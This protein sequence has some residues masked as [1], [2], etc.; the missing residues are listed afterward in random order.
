MDDVEDETAPETVVGTDDTGVVEIAEPGLP[1]ATGEVTPVAPVTASDEASLTPEVV[2]AFEG[3][4]PGATDE[5]AP[6]LARVWIT[7]EVVAAPATP[8]VRVGGGAAVEE[9]AEVSGSAQA[10]PLPSP[11]HATSP[12]TATL[13]SR[14]IRPIRSRPFSHLTLDN[15]STSAC[16]PLQL[17]CHGS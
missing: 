16:R 13:P 1:V 2:D 8:A 5:V 10:C 7:A 3:P 14:P 11:R 17:S 9:R 6:L 15:V 12:R 4:V